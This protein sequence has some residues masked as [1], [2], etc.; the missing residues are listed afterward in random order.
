MTNEYKPPHTYLN[1]SPFVDAQI[2]VGILKVCLAHSDQVTVAPAC[3]E[4]DDP[5][6][7]AGLAIACSD[8]EVSND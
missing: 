7:L 1:V 5:L 6:G 2:L 4:L 3:P 8:V